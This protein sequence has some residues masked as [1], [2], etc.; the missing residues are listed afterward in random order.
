MKSRSAIDTIKG[1]FYQFDYSIKTILETINPTDQITIEG[2]ED[3]DVKTVTEE[4]AIQCKYYSKT[5]YNHSVISK[6]IRLMLSHFISEKNRGNS[7]IKYSLYGHFKSG[8]HKLNLPISVDDLK[9]NFLTYSENKIKQ[10]HHLNIGASDNDLTNFISNLKLDIT[11]QEYE[12][13]L[14]KHLGFIEIKIYL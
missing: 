1:Y 12:V 2:I 11:A 10:H 13:Q 6:P 3:I 5:E 8:H 4:T 14:N 7:S 9:D